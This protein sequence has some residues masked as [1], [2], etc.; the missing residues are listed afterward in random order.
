M[1]D[2]R[3]SDTNPPQIWNPSGS[4]VALL[5]AVDGISIKLSEPYITGIQ[6]SNGT[7]CLTISNLQYG[8]IIK[9]E[10]STN[11]INWTSLQTN[12]ASG[13][14]LSFTNCTSSQVP[15]R[16]FRASAE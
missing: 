5:F 4:G 10:G 7:C 8:Q 14:T 15:C 6:A 2:G 16:F 12:I 3:S 9:L 11:L 1:A 13:V